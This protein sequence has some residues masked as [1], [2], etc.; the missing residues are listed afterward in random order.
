MS[1]TKRLGLIVGAAASLSSAMAQTALDQSRAYQNELFS[2]SAQRVSQQG[3]GAFS[4]DVGGYTQVRLSLNARDDA[5]LDNDIAWGFSNARSRINFGGNVFSEDWGYFVQLGFGDDT[6]VRAPVAGQASQASSGP[7]DSWVFEDAYGTY[8]IGNGWDMKVGQF[9]M[10]FLREELVGDTDQLAVD[11]SITN[12]AFTQARSQGLQLGYSSDSFRFFG[13]ISDGLRTANT[14]YVS[15]AEADFAFTARGEFMWAGAW[16]QAEGFTSWQNSAFFGM[17]G[18]AAHYQTGGGTFNTAAGGVGPGNPPSD[19]ADVDLFG[20]TAD[21]TVKGNGWNAFGAFI[22]TST[23]G[24]N[25]GV[26]NVAYPGTGT[27]GGPG[28]S[29]M[30]DIGLVLQGGIFVAPQWELFGRFDIIMPDSSR[31]TPRDDDFSSLAFG[32]NYYISPDSQAAKF[33]A[34]LQYFLDQETTG[35]A[36]ASTLHGL[37]GSSEDGQFTVTAQMQLVF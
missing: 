10:P 37:L 6:E 22:W 21:V 26:A 27:P 17:V 7:S 14:D 33:T 36:P 3:A 1:L 32:V 35:I 23:D 9:K 16:S 18:A 4:V 28:A 5:S 8:K 15:S 12:S 13:A 25:P 24:G 30:D 2:D 31:T 11:R 19:P 20:L 34:Q 29:S